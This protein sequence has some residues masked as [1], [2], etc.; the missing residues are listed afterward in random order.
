MGGLLD[1]YSFC[2]RRDNEGATS[3]H[4]VEGV[5]S[6]LRCGR[7]K[8]PLSLLIGFSNLSTIPYIG[9]GAVFGVVLLQP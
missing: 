6:E 5:R 4:E 7:A 2:P 9:D 3:P 1:C 8:L